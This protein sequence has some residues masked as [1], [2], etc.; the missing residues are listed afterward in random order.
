MCVG[1][2][3]NRIGVGRRVD[4]VGKQSL[5]NQSVCLGN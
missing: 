1:S 3:S 5:R 2:G 4:R